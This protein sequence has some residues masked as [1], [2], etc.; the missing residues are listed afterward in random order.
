[1]VR[2]DVPARTGARQEN[3]M[4]ITDV[5]DVAAEPEMM[6]SFESPTTRP[7]RGA[8]WGSWGGVGASGYGRLQGKVGLREFAV[9]VHVATNAMPLLK[10]LWWYPCDEATD[11]SL[12]AFSN[13]MSA[14]TFA[15]KLADARSLS[16]HRAR[17]LRAKL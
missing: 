10:R 12:R 14:P 2:D 16:R 11:A 8:A 17:A 1:M 3:A 15:G 9:P 4:G 7:W 6:T 5:G 13:V